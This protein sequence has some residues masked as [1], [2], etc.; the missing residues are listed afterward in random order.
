MTVDAIAALM[1]FGYPKLARVDYAGDSP[2]V[3]DNSTMV[4]T[5]QITDQPPHLLNGGPQKQL[6][7][8]DG[9]RH[10]QRRR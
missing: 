8:H 6:E 5:L 3:V 10:Q 1:E 9:S 4:V 7:G 2:T